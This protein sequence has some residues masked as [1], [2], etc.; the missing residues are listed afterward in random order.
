MQANVPNALAIAVE[1]LLQRH[2]KLLYYN[3]S[4]GCR[5]YNHVSQH[6]KLNYNKLWH[7]KSPHKLNK[8]FSTNQC[9]E[10]IIQIK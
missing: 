9:L 3:L 10:Q 2:Q 4:Y 6:V 1:M 8:E 7:F 5:I